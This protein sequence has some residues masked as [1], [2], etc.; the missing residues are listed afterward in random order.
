[1]GSELSLIMF[2]SIMSDY[3]FLTQMVWVDLSTC[4]GCI[5]GYGLRGCVYVS[6]GY[7][8]IFLILYSTL[9]LC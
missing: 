4:F 1:M 3:Y 6:S 8:I 9:L 2:V 7:R 5:G